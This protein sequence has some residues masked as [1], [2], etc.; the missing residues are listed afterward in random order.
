VPTQFSVTGGPPFYQCVAVSTTSDATGTYQVYALQEP[1]FN[2]YPKLAVWPDAYYVTL[3]MFNGNSF[4]GAR[5]C[6]LNRTA[7]LSGSTAQ[8]I[9]FQEGKSVANLLPSD[10]DG[11]AAPPA[12]LTKLPDEFRD[13]QFAFV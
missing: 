11:S 8:Q 12:G 1:Y 2:D 13:Q 6:A 4:V 9:C 5:A 10:W 3:N 7:M